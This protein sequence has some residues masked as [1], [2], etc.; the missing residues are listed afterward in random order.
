[1]TNQLDMRDLRYF[2][3]IA[4]TGH[5][6][7]AAKLLFRTQPALTG[8]IDRLEET[9]GAALFVREGR[10]IRLTGAGEVLLRRAR[11][12]RIAV[13]DAKREIAEVATGVVGQIR[14]GLLP[15]LATFLFPSI[16]LAFSREARDVRIQTLV[17]QNDLLSRKLR[18]GELDLIVSA[19][20]EVDES[21]VS[22]HVCDDEAVV[23]A[24]QHHP[25]LAR[26]PAL[27]RTLDYRWVLAP[28]DVG[29]RRWL[30]TVFEKNGLRPP[31]VQIETNLLLLMPALIERTDFLTFTSSKHVRTG[32]GWPQLCAI[33][34]PQLTMPR[35][36]DVIYR[37]DAY[38]PAAAARMVDL[39]RSQGSRL[40]ASA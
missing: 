39:L 13:D 17:G 32:T 25:M 11:A 12:L 40:F 21:L 9:L 15:T 33:R 14:V 18:A 29:T 20:L 16:A 1:M 6:G 4:E 37:R 27:R 26:R 28:P 38:L 2:E 5:L 22:H 10:G 24:R 7:R 35:R 19:H 8:C 31:A 36:F 3:V 23:I 34:I 30:E